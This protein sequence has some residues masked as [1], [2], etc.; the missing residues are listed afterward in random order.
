MDSPQIAPPVPPPPGP[1]ARTSPLLLVAVGLGS[2]VVVMTLGI[3]L[4]LIASP[5]LRARLPLLGA[6]VAAPPEAPRRLA[7][8]PRPLLLAET[9]DQPSE[10]WSQTQG[11]VA[12]GAYELRIDTP[13]HDGYGLFLGPPPGPPGEPVSFDPSLIANFDIAVDV[14]QV[15]GDP[16]AEYGVR[17]RQGG[18]EDYLMFSISGS[19]YYR[20][21]RVTGET[22]A[23]IAPWTFDRRIR[24]GPGAVNRLRVI[25]NGT[26][27][28]AAINDVEL[29]TY[30]DL[31]NTPGQLTLG[32]ATFD[33]GGVAVRFSNIVGSAES[34]RAAGSADPAARVDLRE[35]FSDPATVRWS[36]GGTAIVDGALEMTVGGGVQTWQQP[37]PTGASWVDDFVVE[38][39]ATMLEGSEGGSSAGII[40]GDGGEFNFF[41]FYL[42]PEGG[43]WL[44]RFEPTGEPIEI[45]PAALFPA[46]KPGFN[47]TN[48]IRIA[49]RNGRLNIAVNDEQLLD[50]P[51][52]AGLT[53]EGRVGM[54]VNGGPESGTRVRFDNF[55]LEEAGEGES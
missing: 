43:V 51:L 21:V 38:V 23:S 5:E 25:A 52:A 50:A 8:L 40:F 39:D 46:V 9:F 3:V 54:I 11:R 44:M 31:I 33:Q 27:I 53:I 45:I 30:T 20:L 24:T 4:L 47:V 6:G 1:P 49:K 26:A 7:P 2:F 16:T 32:V 13:N 15:A 42:L 37:L 48:R 19:G 28:R 18:P 36:V 17:F 41:A 12:D 55:R 35:D 29:V 10:R 22:Y 14:A 34:G